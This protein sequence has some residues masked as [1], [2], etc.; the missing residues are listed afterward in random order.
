MTESHKSNNHAGQP[1]DRLE[2]FLRMVIAESGTQGVVEC[3]SP[4]LG[5]FCITENGVVVAASEAFLSLA[6]YTRAALYGKHATELIT[7][8]ERDR[9]QTRLSLADDSRY[10]LNLLCQSGRVKRVMVSPR[11]FR[12]GDVAY[13]LAECIDISPGYDYRAA[14]HE[15]ETHYR[16]VFDHAAVGIARVGVDG[17]YLEVNQKLCD[18]LGYSEE[19]LKSTTFQ[20][21]THPDDL[22]TDLSL[23]NETLAGQRSTYAMEKRFFHKLRHIVW[24]N[25]TVSLVRQLSGAPEYFIS[26]VEDIS[27]RKKI[28]GELSFRASHDELTRLGNRRA[29]DEQLSQEVA[30][31]AR[32]GHVL[33]VVMIDI[34]HFKQV[35]DSFGHPV[36]DQVL[37]RLAEALR[38]AIRRI[39]FVG[40][41]GGEEFLMVLPQLDHDAALLTAERLRKM[42]ES[43]PV[44]TSNHTINITVSLGVATMPEHGGTAED[45]LK[46]ADNAMYAAKAGGRNQVASAANLVE[47]PLSGS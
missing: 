14:L 46:Q 45:L 3:F 23:F 28:E 29:V 12:A 36:G 41:F 30:R 8:D 39:D 33:S 11:I 22:D 6:E 47:A 43:N 21:L 7:E 13:Q 42:V 32:Y 24:T 4:L 5:A 35:N 17:E 27:D 44:K 1:A 40:R 34:D 19:E 9:M 37:K 38:D 2:A 20:V 15:S 18:I 10:E 16:S 25:L 26:V 31:A